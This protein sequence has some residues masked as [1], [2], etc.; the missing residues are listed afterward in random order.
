M[1]FLNILCNKIKKA[2][3]GY[4]GTKRIGRDK[5]RKVMCR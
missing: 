5:Q 1:F 3:H 2:F 4:L